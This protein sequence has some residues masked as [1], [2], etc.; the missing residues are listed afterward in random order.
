MRLPVSCPSPVLM[1][2]FSWS[3]STLAHSPC[4]S[5]TTTCMTKSFSLFSRPSKPGNT[6]WRTLPPWWM[7]LPI[8]KIL[9]IS[10]PQRFSL[11]SRPGG[12]STSANSTWLSVSNLVSLVLS[13]T[14]WLDNGMSTP[15]RGIRAS[16]KWTHRTSDWCLQLNS[17]Q[18]HF[19]LP[20]WRSLFS[21]PVHLWTLSA[22]TPTS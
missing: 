4:P 7:L 10:L 13:P 16:P 20:I 18:T 3:P 11:V 17:S 8:T 22:S 9:S 1:A 19:A 21:E 14:P 2:R 5:W 6:T 15:K 12:Q